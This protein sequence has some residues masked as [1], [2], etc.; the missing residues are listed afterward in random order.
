MKPQN[1]THLAI[2]S[3]T[4]TAYKRRRRKKTLFQMW[5]MQDGSGGVLV[6]AIAAIVAAKLLQLLWALFWRPYALT[7]NFRNQ[8]IRGPP[9]HFYHGSLRE[10]KELTRNAAKLVLDNSS[11]DITPRI[12]PHYDKW[13][14]EYGETLVYWHGLLPRITITDPELVK[15][16]LSNKFGFYVK[17]MFRPVTVIAKGLV[18]LH[19]PQWATR[20]RLLN[21]A[22]SMEKLKPMMHKIGSCTLEMVSEWGNRARE[23]GGCAKVEANAEFQRLTA[24]IISHTAFGSSYLQGKEAFQALRQLQ[25]LSAAKI[26]DVF[27]PGSQYVPTPSNMEIWKLDRTLKNSLMNIIQGK[28]AASKS[29]D[30]GYGDDLLGMM[31]E[32]SETTK[33]AKM[34]MNEIM[35]ECRT[36]YFAGHETTS[37]LL[38][39]AIFLLTMHQEWQHKLRDEVL[40]E[41]GMEIPDADSLSKLKLVNMVLLETLRLYSP[42]I[43]MMRMAPQDMK[44]G[45]LQIPKGTILSIPVLKIHRSKEL[46]GDDANEFKPMRFVNGVSMAATHPNAFLPFGMGPRVCIGQNFAMME[47]K[48][49]LALLL[50]RFSFTLSPDY[51]HTPTNNLT[52]QPQYGLP[53]FVKPL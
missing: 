52:L 19:G 21:P 3:V 35:D 36:F 32:A 28:V 27:I 45:K 31:I 50:Q 12:N 46:W 22:F 51:K 4:E 2:V 13:F 24:D 44:L 53:V 7:K 14:P 5:Y 16:I 48:S 38:T 8:G 39:W 11:N 1:P 23:G 41:C 15:Q 20:R 40:R 10:V 6:V 18:L 37:N 29:S 26:A 17:P 25:L 33:G 34:N 43:E 49:V 30:V 47:A 42:A 9:R